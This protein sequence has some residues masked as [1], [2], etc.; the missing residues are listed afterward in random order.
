[1][2]E[3]QQLSANT[4]APDGGN[5]LRG[6]FVFLRADGL[7]LLMPL[8]D[9]VQMSYFE[10]AEAAQA[11]HHLSQGTTFEIVTQQHEEQQDGLGNVAVSQDLKLLPSLPDDRYILTQMAG[12]YVRFAWA[13]MAILTD[14]T[15]PAEPIPAQFLQDSCP[16]TALVSFAEQPAFFCRADAFIAYVFPGGVPGAQQQERLPRR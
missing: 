9:I 2:H 7:R 6:D 3:Q 4:S 12:A 13:E 10:D 16:L 14:Q 8:H 5:S 11:F 15:L 1:M